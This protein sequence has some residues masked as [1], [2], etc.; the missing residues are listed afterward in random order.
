MSDA[1]DVSSDEEDVEAF[2]PFRA[3][4]IDAEGEAQY[5]TADI[6]AAEGAGRFKMK[7]PRGR[8]K[9]RRR[10]TSAAAARRRV[11]SGSRAAAGLCSSPTST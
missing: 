9:A 10:R 1:S 11:R 7:A 6:D 3:L 2:N 5:G 4:G 8:R